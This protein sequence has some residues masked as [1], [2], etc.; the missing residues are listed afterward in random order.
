LVNG[1]IKKNQ[2]FG[3]YI[4]DEIDANGED[5]EENADP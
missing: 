3:E 5:S 2:N 1:L 4:Y